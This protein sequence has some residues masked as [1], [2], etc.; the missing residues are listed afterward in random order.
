GAITTL[1]TPLTAVGGA[2]V[3]TLV[4]LVPLVGLP[5]SS[6]HATGPE[7]TPD[8]ETPDHETP[9][10]TTDRDPA[11]ADPS[12]DER[13][14]NDP[15]AT[16]SSDGQRPGDDTHRRDEPAVSDT[17]DA[18][19]VA[20]RLADYLR[21]TRAGLRAV[22]RHGLW[23]LVGASV[24]INLVAPAYGLLFAAVGDR[25]GTALAYAALVVGYDLGK[26]AGNAV[27]PRLDWSRVLA[28]RRGI[29]LLGL[30]T[31]AFGSV[32]WLL[33]GGRATVAV[34]LLAVGTAVVG[35]TQP[36]FN[37][38]S[39]GLVQRAVPDADR[40]TVVTV[41]NALYQLPFPL[42]YLGGG[43]LAERLSPF[44][45]FVVAGAFL[46]V[47]ASVAAVTLDEQ[48]TREPTPTATD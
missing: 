17:P 10:L 37:V 23:P 15:T 2:G 7:A 29:A 8:H 34:P 9:D 20:G 46:L 43:L 14:T 6:D 42:A 3:V 31:L 21:E 30:T 39:D 47:V 33:A 28:V 16:D 45:G 25:F 32:G 18:D 40:G 41:T 26:V 36:V 27:V 48:T 35:A 44:T 4:A 19:G 22:G 38:P 13:P 1:T 5:E 12:S 24:G 11:T